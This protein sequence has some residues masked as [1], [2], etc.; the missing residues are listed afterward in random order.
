MKKRLNRLDKRSQGEQTIICNDSSK[1][2]A[3]D[4]PV[5]IL[6]HESYQAIHVNKQENSV[7]VRSNDSKLFS[8]TPLVPR[9]VCNTLE[10]RIEHLDSSKSSYIMK[11]VSDNENR[12]IASMRDSGPT[13]KT[14][15]IQSRGT[16]SGNSR[17]RP[18]KKALTPKHKNTQEIPILTS[19]L[20]NDVVVSRCSGKQLSFRKPHS[21]CSHD[22]TDLGRNL[23]E[24]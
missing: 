22:N 6:G 21:D 19:K 3:P 24:K 15:I 5:Q 1:Y 18:V 16:E 8:R 2:E 7:L 17:N 23:Y 13:D 14:P 10:E 20:Y 12:S 9:G 4:Q 11:R